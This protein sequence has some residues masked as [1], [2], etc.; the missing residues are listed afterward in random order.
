MGF[1][2]DWIAPTSTTSRKHAHKK[3]STCVNPKCN[4]KPKDD[5]GSCG[6]AKCAKFVTRAW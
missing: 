4:K 3:A 5:H 2:E 6:S 1:F